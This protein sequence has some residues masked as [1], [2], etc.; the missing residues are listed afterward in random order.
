MRK[1]LNILYVTTPNAYLTKD[2]ENV[3]ISIEGLKKMQLP[4]HTLEGIVCFGYC[5]AS[6][7]LM[8][9]CAQSG[10]GLSFHDPNGRFMA[11]V[12][13]PVRGNVLLRK[14]QYFAAM[15]PDTAL[16][17]SRNI[18]SAKVT[19]SR[20]VLQ[21][22]AREHSEDKAAAALKTTA[23]K[24]KRALFDIQ[25]TMDPASLRGVEGDC[26]KLYFGVFDHM[27]LQ[28]K[29]AFVFAGRSK[30]PPTDMVN[31]LLSFLYTMLAHDV[32]SALESVGLD[33]YMGFLHQP[34]PGRP[35]LALDIME[36]FRAVLADR[37]ALSLINKRQLNPKSFVF[38]ENG[39]VLLDPD[40][41]KTVLEAWFN[42]KKDL[43]QHPFLQEK[44]EVGLLPYAQAL[45]LARYLRGD[46]EAY[47]P[48][49]QK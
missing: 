26:A 28:Q 25:K 40:H 31:A 5:G 4:I 9:F 19:N 2:G 33:P 22:A 24:L 23:D 45:L 14:R 35:S 13:G 37:V 3:V 32:Q 12:Q 42:R 15:A 17:I 20:V 21:R 48:F 6:P 18:I 1:L 38:K 16:E 41:K 49:I 43:V 10:V 29:E 11:R 36:E 34:R 8:H 44:M 30:R 27:L 7:A 47:P 39:T 46:L